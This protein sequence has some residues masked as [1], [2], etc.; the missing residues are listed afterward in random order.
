MVQTFTLSAEKRSEMTGMIKGYFLSER[1]QEL[2][3]LAAGLILDFF[4]QKLAPEFYNQGVY[5]AYRYTVRLVED[6]LSLQKF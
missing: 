5:D 3:D 6:V 4:M 1:D 2:G